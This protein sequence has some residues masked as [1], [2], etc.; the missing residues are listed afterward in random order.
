[1]TTIGLA[2]NL[3]VTVN[4]EGQEPFD[5]YFH[6]LDAGAALVLAGMMTLGGYELLGGGEQIPEA[7]QALILD[8][9]ALLFPDM[10]LALSIRAQKI[11]LLVGAKR[12]VVD[13]RLLVEIASHLLSQPANNS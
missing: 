13:V 2:K 11:R 8:G 6:R 1:M 7:S 4:H 10:P 12:S 3:Q 5:L 9:A